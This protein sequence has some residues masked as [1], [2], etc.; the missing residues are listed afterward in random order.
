MA[1]EGSKKFSEMDFFRDEP[2]FLQRTKAILL[3]WRKWRVT[4]P[5]IKTY[6]SERGFALKK[7]L[8]EDDGLGT[9]LFVQEI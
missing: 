3:E 7:I 1:S 6:L 2:L 9:A 5:E 8:H 4:L